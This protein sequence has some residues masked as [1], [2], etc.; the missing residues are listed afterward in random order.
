MKRNRREF[1]GTAAIA[2]AGMALPAAA[3]PDPL[4]FDI[5]LKGGR[6]F[7]NGR[8][9]ALDIGIKGDHIA[10]LGSPGT[11]ADKAARTMDCAGMYI[12]PGWVDLHAHLIPPSH[13]RIGC[14]LS[15]A[16]AC[17]GVTAILEAGT[18]GANNFGQFERHAAQGATEE[19]FALMNIKK[20]G[21]RLRDLYNMKKGQEDLEM[22]ERVADGNPYIKGL[23][24]RPSKENIDRSDPL[25]YVRKVREAADLLGLRIMVHISAPPPMVTEVFP[26][27]REGDILTHCL[28]NTRNNILQGNGKL[29]P[30]TLDA[31]D[32]GVLF[33]IGHGFASF[34]FEAAE[35]ALG[36]SFTDFTI[37][38]DL[39]VASAAAHTRTFANVMTNLLAAGMSLGD[40][41]ERVTARPAKILGIERELG[42]GKTATLTVFSAPTG[43]FECRD[44]PGEKRIS[45]QRIFPEWAIIKGQVIRAG[46]IDRKLYL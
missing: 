29:R 15:R 23:K 45:R 9:E 28:R 6:A 46:E 12:S 22:M 7:L 19:V 21:F 20:D 13:K 25:Y 31:I 36:Q 10:A 2:A 40:V 43:E 1:I 8:F 3:R 27:M 4:S 18:T 37:S 30:E 5:I 11:V 14:S 17:S 33:D 34:T 44:C 39:W 38:S 42:A 41:V 24:V 26:Y 32:R 35:K 16:G